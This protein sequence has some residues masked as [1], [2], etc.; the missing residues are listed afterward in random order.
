MFAGDFCLKETRWSCFLIAIVRILICVGT[1]AAAFYN[2][3]KFAIFIQLL[4]SVDLALYKCLF[5]L[6]LLLTTFYYFYN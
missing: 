2:Q 3:T 1:T 5:L 4:T 6:L